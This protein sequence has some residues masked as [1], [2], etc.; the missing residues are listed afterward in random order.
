MTAAN[1]P[2][3]VA[4]FNTSP[5]LVDMLRGVFEMAGFVV[6]SLLTFQI[7]EGHVDV[8]TFLGQQ[9]PDVI[10]YDLAPPY[11]PNWRL[12]KHVCRTPAMRQCRIVLTS[13]NAARV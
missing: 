2:K 4:I 6:V 13:T 3:V 5:D 11:E 9:K 1:D 7:R 10:V 12:F 8:E